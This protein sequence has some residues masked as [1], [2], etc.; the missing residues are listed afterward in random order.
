MGKGGTTKV[1]LWTMVQAKTRLP[2]PSLLG[3]AGKKNG[4]TVQLAKAETRVVFEQAQKWRSGSECGESHARLWPLKGNLST[5]PG[6]PKVRRNFFMSQPCVCVGSRQE[7]SV[8][9]GES[10]KRAV[11][12]KQP[13]TC[14]VG[15]ALSF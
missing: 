7:V 3:P 1:K 15:C 11:D 6:N 10:H 12:T 4:G 13:H 9:L 14:W 2:T 5:W 8:V